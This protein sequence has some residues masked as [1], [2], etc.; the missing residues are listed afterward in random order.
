MKCRQTTVVRVGFDNSVV[1]SVKLA[2]HANTKGGLWFRK[3]AS[4]VLK[5]AAALQNIPG[6]LG[7]GFHKQQA[8][9]NFPSLKREFALPTPFR[10]RIITGMD[11]KKNSI[12]ADGIRT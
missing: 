3:R 8:G 7:A 2:A 5:G 12:L 11:I 9:S 10:K 6:G 4:I 1:G